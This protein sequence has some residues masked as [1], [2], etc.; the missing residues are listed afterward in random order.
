VVVVTLIAVLCGALVGFGLLLMRSAFTEAPIAK[1]AG[2]TPDNRRFVR[3]AAGVASGALVGL[4]TG[5]PVAALG[6]VVAGYVVGG[7]TRNGRRQAQ[8]EIER[9]EAL[10]TWAEMLRDTLVAGQGITETIRSTAEVAPLP[11]RPEVQKLARRVQHQR[12]TAALHDWADEM[13]DAT[14]DLIASVL[15]LAATRSGR[16]VGSLLSAMAKLARERVAMRLRIDARRAS[17]RSEARSLV[18][19]SGLFFAGLALF[20]GSFVAPYKTAAGQLVLAVVLGMAGLAISW[21]SKLGRFEPVPRVLT[22][23]EAR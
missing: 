13:N 3:L 14:A 11:I 4:A 1:N 9:T 15:M 6:G 17:T 22:F 12:L 18:A 23:A 10:A 16:D 7:M 2:V 21:L 19:F 5:W 8:I 20:S